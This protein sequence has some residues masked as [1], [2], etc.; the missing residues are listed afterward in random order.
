[1]TRNVAFVIYEDASLL[2]LM[3]FLE[4]F[5]Q[6]QLERGTKEL[7]AYN[8][9][10]VSSTG[11]TIRTYFGLPMQTSSV[12]DLKQE[13]IDTLILTGGLGFREAL[14]DS[15]LIDWIGTKGQAV[16][17][18]C[19]VG[20]GTFLAAEAGLLNGRRVVTHWLMNDEFRSRYPKVKL[21]SDLIFV[22][23]GNI[24]SSAGMSSAMDFAL[25]VVEDDLGRRIAFRLAERLVMF[26]KRSGSQP[27]IGTILRLQAR[28]DGQFDKLHEWILAHLDGDLHVENLAARAGMST[29]N[30]G[31]VY[32][33]KIGMTP[34]KFVEIV[35]VETASQA[36]A[37]SDERISTI[38]HRCG[39]GDEQ[40]MRRAFLRLRGIGPLEYRTRAQEI[41]AADEPKDTSN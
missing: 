37:G 40:R 23:D 39:F 21:E 12:S 15:T 34:S 4:T 6:L 30:F 20:T 7:P 38:A 14:A 31:R 36:L 29:R 3:G 17:R 19:S 25:A 1:M 11:G 2:T 33:N 35:R 10:V 27:Q 5:Q 16:T 9:S 28:D 32:L 24:W 8:I 13:R 41:P 22:R 18:L 26:L